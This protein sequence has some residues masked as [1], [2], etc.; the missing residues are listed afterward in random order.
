MHGQVSLFQDAKGESAIKLFGS[1]FVF[2]T[3]NENLA[4]SLDLFKRSDISGA[5]F[6]KFNRWAFNLDLAANEG[7]VNL[8]T[9]DGFL[10]DGSVGVYRGWKKAAK[11]AGSGSGWAH[12]TFVSGNLLVDRNK[13]YNSVLPSDD[14]IYT[15]G[16][17]GWKFETGRFG[18]VGDF[19]YG[20]TASLKQQTNIGDLTARSVQFLNYA[21]SD[22]SLRVYTTKSAFDVSQFDG[23]QHSFNLNAD[24]LLLINRTAATSGTGIPTLFFGLHARLRKVFE[25]AIQFNPALGLY[26]GK[27]GAPRNIIGGVNLQFVDLFNGQD[28]NTGVWRRTALNVS[29]GF[30]L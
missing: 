30:R 10:I 15:K 11:A 1:A 12:E 13:L 26:I 19:L 25:Q 6:D 18:Y 27:P 28:A 23:R 4:V 21:S 22:D 2:N 16:H 5:S 8:K 3:T 29:I 7:L 14:V 17:L 24:G 20:L 9:E